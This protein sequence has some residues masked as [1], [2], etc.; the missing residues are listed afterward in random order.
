MEEHQKG[1]EEWVGL[2]LQE[3]VS[4]PERLDQETG[5]GMEKEKVQQCWLVALLRGL[6]DRVK[7][8]V[9]LQGTGGRPQRGVV[10]HL[11]V[12]LSLLEKDRE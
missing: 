12:R 2:C 8:Y 3:W 1:W 10:E 7:S 5:M 11:E 4:Y 9:E 6:Q